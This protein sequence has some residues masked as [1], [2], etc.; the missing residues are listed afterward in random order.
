MIKV[1]QL[2]DHDMDQIFHGSKEAV[3]AAEDVANVAATE[4]ISMI[5][6]S[7]PHINLSLAMRELRSALNVFHV[8]REEE[9]EKA[10]Q[11]LDDRLKTHLVK[12]MEGYL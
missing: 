2:T 10:N 6:N 7:A 12:K 3:D 5:M 4:A 8:G 1:I 11:E 9:V